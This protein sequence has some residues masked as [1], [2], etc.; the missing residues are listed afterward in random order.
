MTGAYL[1]L[2]CF[3]KTL[4]GYV[5]IDLTCEKADVLCDMREYIPEEQVV[6]VYCRWSLGFLEEPYEMLERICF[7]ISQGGHLFLTVREEDRTRKISQKNKERGALIKKGQGLYGEKVVRKHLFKK[8]ELKAF[9]KKR[10]FEIL[11]QYEG[12]NIHIEAFKIVPKA[13]KMFFL[14][15]VPAAG[16]TTAVQNLINFKPFDSRLIH[17]SEDWSFSTVGE[18][19][20]NSYMNGYEALPIEK[21]LLY[22]KV[23]AS[24]TENVI[25]ETCLAGE[26]ELTEIIAFCDANAI[27]FIP[28]ELIVPESTLQLR[29]ARRAELGHEMYG[30]PYTEANVEGYQKRFRN[31]RVVESLEDL[32]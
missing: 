17:I 6:D 22:L 10:G 20:I 8:N 25:F 24:L 15:G 3:R 26:G 2:G 29:R 13:K 21:R 7:W 1:N 31:R 16:K 11:V 28:V 4:R 27:E 9:F 18:N 30:L 5:N 32:K 12:P 23:A 19:N 14:F